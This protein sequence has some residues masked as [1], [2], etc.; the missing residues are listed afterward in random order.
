MNASIYDLMHRLNRS[1][2]NHILEYYTKVS[3][4]F[5]SSRPCYETIPRYNLAQFNRQK[6]TKPL[7][8]QLISETNFISQIYYGTPYQPPKR[9]FYLVKFLD[10]GFIEAKIMS[11][12]INL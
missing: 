1:H 10:P 9:L 5:R 7:R 4:K 8:D 12:L 11:Y 6:E 2:P 3:Q